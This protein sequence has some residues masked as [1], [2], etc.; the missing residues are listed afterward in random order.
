MKQFTKK[1][2]LSLGISLTIVPVVVV[3]S[4]GNTSNNSIKNSIK[5]DNVK[6]VRE[7]IT[8]LNQNSDFI[9][10]D[11]VVAM[12]NPLKNTSNND[13]YPLKKEQYKK[14]A[15]YMGRI[16]DEKIALS[17]KGNVET[18][19]LNITQYTKIAEK[20]I[21]NLISNWS[22]P[23]GKIAAKLMSTRMNDAITNPKYKS[24]DF[25][26]YVAAL[27]PITIGMKSTGFLSLPE[28]AWQAYNNE[29]KALNDFSWSITSSNI[30][31]SWYKNHV[32]STLTPHIAATINKNNQ[33][34]SKGLLDPTKIN[35][36]KDKGNTGVNFDQINAVH[37]MGMGKP[38]NPKKMSNFAAEFVYVLQD[39]YA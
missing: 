35:N 28:D 8:T 23:N 1:L 14:I 30:Y 18:F 7:F 24:P 5:L 27:T 15:H 38:L 36:D 12:G 20:S 34:A 31:K 19:K 11:S 9:M 39:L 4:C 21:N 29:L 2:T 3:A 26:S 16:K 37:Y 6:S 25:M 32:N 13:N 22:D 33:I 17:Y 10:P